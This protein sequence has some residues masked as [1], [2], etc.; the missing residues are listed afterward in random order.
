MRPA[1]N[2]VR[3]RLNDCSSWVRRV[4]LDPNPSV[5]LLQSCPRLGPTSFE[6]YVY[7]AVVRGYRDPASFWHW[8]RAVTR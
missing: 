3:V 6:F 8:R 4:A 5:S 1:P 7:E 2:I